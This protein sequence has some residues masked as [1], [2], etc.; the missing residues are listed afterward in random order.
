MAILDK[1]IRDALSF[2]DKVVD[3]KKDETIEGIVSTKKVVQE[4]GPVQS[5]M[6]S[7]DGGDAEVLETHAH[8]GIL[9]PRLCHELGL[10]TGRTKVHVNSERANGP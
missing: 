10:K 5:A 1:K 3:A 8:G 7:K 6:V 4:L 9:R 2:A